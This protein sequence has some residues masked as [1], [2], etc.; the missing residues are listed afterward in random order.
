MNKCRAIPRVWGLNVGTKSLWI[1]R[2]ILKSLHCH[3]HRWFS[4]SE[5]WTHPCHV[6]PAWAGS[7]PQVRRWGVWDAH[8]KG[9]GTGPHV[10]LLPL[11]LTI[12][13]QC[14]GHLGVTV[15]CLPAP[16]VGHSM[17]H[18]FHCWCR[19]QTTSCRKPWLPAQ[20]P[21]PSLHKHWANTFRFRVERQP[22]YVCAHWVFKHIGL[23]LISS[24]R[25]LGFR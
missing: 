6:G 12:Q 4:P 3:T 13:A 9:L 2:D 15:T 1:A 10:W 18:W 25:Y 19:P 23:S 24:V 7:G 20:I 5:C 17:E 14:C 22:Y 11:H 21:F 16:A 8:R